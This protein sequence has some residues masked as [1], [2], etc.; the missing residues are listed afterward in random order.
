MIIPAILS[1]QVDIAKNTARAGAN[2]MGLEALS[3]L[4]LA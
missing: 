4:R 3:S 2:R 1:G